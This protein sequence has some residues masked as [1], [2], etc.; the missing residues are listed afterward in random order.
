MLPMRQGTRPRFWHDPQL[1]DQDR[2]RHGRTN[3]EQRVLLPWHA[4][5]NRPFPDFLL[6][7]PRIPDQQHLDHLVGPGL[8]RDMWVSIMFGAILR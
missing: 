4:T 3:V 7:P 2:D 5:T 6:C 8:R 1:H